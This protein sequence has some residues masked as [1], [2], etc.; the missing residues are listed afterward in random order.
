MSE[1]KLKSTE[2]GQKSSKKKPAGVL[3]AKIEKRGNDWAAKIPALKFSVADKSF[4]RL[5]SSLKKIIE[6]MV[7]KRNF[8]VLIEGSASDAEVLIVPSDPKILKQVSRARNKKFRTY[9]VEIKGGKLNNLS[10]GLDYDLNPL[11]PYPTFLFIPHK[12][13]FEHH[14]IELTWKEAKRLR[15]WLNKMSDS[16]GSDLT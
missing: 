8:K 14:H 5:R 6:E 7:G 16:F 15:D 3:V 12:Q 10:I 2:R 9:S 1:S 4:P 11:K 13:K